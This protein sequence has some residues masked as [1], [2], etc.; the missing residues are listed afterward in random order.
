[1]NKKRYTRRV[2]QQNK[3]IRFLI[4]TIV[5]WVND[6][7]HSRLNL[8]ESS[9]RRPAVHSS[10]SRYRQSAR[11]G[12]REGEVL[13]L[14]MQIKLLAI[15]PYQ[16]LRNAHHAFDAP[17]WRQARPFEQ[18]NGVENGFSVKNPAAGVIALTAIQAATPALMGGE[19][20]CR[21]ALFLPVAVR[22]FGAGGSGAILRRGKSSSIGS[23]LPLRGADEP[24]I[25]RVG[26]PPCGKGALTFLRRAVGFIADNNVSGRQ[27]VAKVVV[28]HRFSSSNWRG[29][30]THKVARRSIHGS[31]TAAV[32]ISRICLD[33]PARWV[34]SAGDR[35][36][37]GVAGY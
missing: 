19:A 13:R 4:I 16:P 1:M 20:K 28:G 15:D 23:I 9:T 6:G 34:L 30:S 8:N 22:V 37:P 11:C 21:K 32:S 24:A 31:Y 12:C 25:A 5:Y 7:N 3:G 33:G 18:G 10:R 26:L 29:S 2:Q 14:N 27:L 17:D 36:C 35:V